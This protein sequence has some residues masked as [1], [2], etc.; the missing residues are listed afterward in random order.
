MNNEKSDEQTSFTEPK[1]DDLYRPDVDTN[2]V[3][4]QKLMRRIDLHVIPWLAML[5]FLNF[6]DRGNIG[7]AKLYGMTTNIDHPISDTQYLIALT[8]YFFPYALL[9]P[10]SNVILRRLKPSLWLSSLIFCWGVVVICHGFIQSY[11][12]LVTVRVLLGVTEAGMYP[13]IVFYISSWYKRS[14]M[15]SKIAFFFSS[16]TL[17]GAFSGLLSVAIHNMDGVGGLAGWRWIFILEGLFTVIVALLSFW[18]IQ[19]YPEA[20]RFLTEEERVFVIRRLKNDVRLSAA[21]EKFKKKYVWQ[22]LRDWKTWVAMGIYMGFDGPLYAFSLFLPTIINEM[23][24][25]SSANLLTIP[26]YAWG[27]ITTVAV[28][29]LG[30]RIGTRYYMSLFLFATGAAGYIILIASRS[31][32]LSYFAVFLAAS[33]IYPS[34][35]NNVAWVA[36]NVEGAYKRSVTLGMAIGWGNINGAVTSNIYRSVD[37]P[38]YTMGHGIV[39]AYIGIGLICVT[40]MRIGLQRENAR[41]DRGE[42][43]E[44]IDG[45]DNKNADDKNGHY[46]TVEAARLDKGD[47]W[48]GFQYSL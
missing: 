36:G 31:P 4:E 15:G 9:E 21:G 32:A 20:A 30:D 2:G 46:P 13:G 48:S 33:A 23:L 43:D 12:G 45:L 29:V 34:I 47:D 35:P 7:N 22:S 38:W 25:Y 5:Y 16:A 37:S 24:P 14:E 26:P 18:V 44:V 8:V 42:R 6:M 3:D 17:S 11:G 1:A 19:D 27:C 28:G 10:A 39:L 40:V 41:R